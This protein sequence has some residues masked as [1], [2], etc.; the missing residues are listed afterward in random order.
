M[1]FLPLLKWQ[2]FLH[3]GVVVISLIL[4]D[5]STEQVSVYICSHLFN[6]AT[7]FPEANDPAIPHIVCHSILA[8]CI[9]SFQ[10]DRRVVSAYGHVRYSHEERATEDLF[11][12]DLNGRIQEC[13]F[14]IV[15]SR[16][17]SVTD[18]PPVHIIGNGVEEV[19]LGFLF[20]KLAEKIVDRLG[21]GSH[22]C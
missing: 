21:G 8:F 13:L 7:L 1:I 3:E 11:V 17:L 5:R 4:L 19:L 22:G 15:G 18:E 10:L 16:H 2:L 12:Q 9:N 14:R 6:Q 20:G